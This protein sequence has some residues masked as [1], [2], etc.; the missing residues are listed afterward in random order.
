MLNNH[1]ALPRQWRSDNPGQIAR[2]SLP[3][4]FEL[5][6]RDS[7]G[8]AVLKYGFVLKQW[9]VNR[10]NYESTHS[11]IESWCNKIGGYRVP[12]VSD[13]TNA[14]CQGRYSG[15]ECQGAVGATP[16]SPDNRVGRHIGAG[17]FTE[18]GIM[19]SYTGY[20]GANFKGNYSYR[21]SYLTSDKSSHNNLIFV[22]SGYNGGVSYRYT[23]GKSYGLCVYP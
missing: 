7:S 3:Q 23:D 8:N 10:G 19:S 1:C 13:L 18:W 4:V 16:S 6:G 2:L 14:T 15:P 9:F 5:V 21:G 17:F 22:I 11:S 20:P 12:K